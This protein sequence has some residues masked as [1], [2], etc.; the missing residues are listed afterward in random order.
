MTNLHQNIMRRVYYIFALKVATHPIFTH[1]LLLGISIFALSRV[2]SIPN[3]LLNLMEVKVGETAHFFFSALLNTQS[4]TIVWLA[5]I[6][7]TTLSLLWRLL[8]GHS[9][10]LGRKTKW[11]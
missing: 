3:V 6:T 7:L 2:V 1:S 4:A 8:G 11:A 10:N 5:I 9:F